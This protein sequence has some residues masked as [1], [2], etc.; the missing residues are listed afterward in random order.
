MW[1]AFIL[2]TKVGSP[3]YLLWIAPLVPL[4][5]LGGSDRKLAVLLV[6]GMVVT[7]LIFPCQYAQ[8]RGELVD[9]EPT[10]AGPTPFGYA[11][12]IAKSGILSVSFV[13]LAVLVSRAKW[14]STQ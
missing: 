14:I 3:Q 7:T 6:A 13:W 11:L 8:V 10:W 9:D 1:L 4:L 2:F 12:L 5:P